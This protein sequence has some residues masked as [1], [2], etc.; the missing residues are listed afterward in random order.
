[1]KICCKNLKIFVNVK[2]IFQNMKHI[3]YLLIHA[4][5]FIF[6]NNFAA[7]STYL[8]SFDLE[9]CPIPEF[10]APIKDVSKNKYFPVEIFPQIFQL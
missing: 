7:S 8:P 5:I 2:S 9:I 1:M 10:S 3:C 4:N 6:I